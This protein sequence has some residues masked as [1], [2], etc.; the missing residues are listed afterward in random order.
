MALSFNLGYQESIS[1]H[2]TRR[3][4]FAGKV[5]SNFPNIWQWLICSILEQLTWCWWWWE[6]EEGNYN[7][8]DYKISTCRSK[9]FKICQVGTLK[10]TCIIINLYFRR[11]LA[12]SNNQNFCCFVNYTRW[13]EASFR[14]SILPNR[15]YLSHNCLPVKAMLWCKT[16]N[17]YLS[18]VYM[19]PPYPCHYVTLAGRIASLQGDAPEL[20][21]SYL[22]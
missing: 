3:P 16:I 1:V 4:N 12:V 15:T 13:K 19:P 6:C 22:A 2:P 9:A 21:I 17:I 20:W 8:Y 11:K 7:H 18:I 10:T 14:A 5:Y